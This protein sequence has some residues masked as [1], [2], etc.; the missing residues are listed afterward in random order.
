MAHASSGQKSNSSYYERCAKAEQM[1][2]MRE[3][4]KKTIEGI[5]K[6]AA[7]TDAAIVQAKL[8]FEVLRKALAKARDMTVG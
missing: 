2:S 3:T 4:I 6:L 7:Q 5:G 8:S 1:E